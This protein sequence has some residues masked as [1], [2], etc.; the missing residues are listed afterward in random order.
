MYIEKLVLSNIRNIEK[1]EFD[2]K[3]GCN[4]I[5]GNN[6][7]GKTS[8]LEAINLLGFGRSFRTHKTQDLVKKGT[9]N[10]TVS[11]RG[12]CDELVNRFGI[13][14]TLN[15]KSE[16][17]IDGKPVRKQSELSSFF[18]IVNCS[19]LSTSLLEDG[20]LVRRRFLDWLVFHVEHETISQVYREYDRSIEQR[21]KSLKF[22]DRRL[23]QTWQPKLVELNNQISKLRANVVEQFSPILLDTFSLLGQ[24]NLLAQRQL[25]VEYKRG[26]KEAEDI[27][28][29]L[30]S[31]IELDLKRGSTQYG[32]HKDELVFKIDDT[33]A[34]NILSRGEQKILLICM[35]LAASQFIEKNSSKK[36]I[37]LIDD[38][39]A[40]LDETT[41]TK[42]IK[43]LV[44]LE[45]QVIIT[46]IKKDLTLIQQLIDREYQ[47]FHV[48][49]G[50]QV[51]IDE[52]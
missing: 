52:R 22:G 28:D 50:T 35:L 23:A 18:P 7:S 30:N 49:H 12:H 3:P 6:G 42:L 40:E 29:I 14:K 31:S 26:W 44:N 45:R 43:Y 9:D 15:G 13:R 10:L 47:V 5:V 4:L 36:C 16:I 2:L 34:K 25:K 37:W 48:E 41:L 20:P 27:G 21:N 38:V 1:L 24:Q 32:V 19:P 39:V 51:L 17:R 11:V 46:S 8:I 33:P